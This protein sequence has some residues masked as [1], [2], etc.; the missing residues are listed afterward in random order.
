VAQSALDR[1]ALREA[2]A[3]LDVTLTPSTESALER[4]AYL[5]QAANRDQNLTRITAPAD[6]AVQHVADSLACLAVLDR[7]RPLAVADVGSGAGWPGLA[8]AIACPRWS[9]TLIE[10]SLKKSRFLAAAVRELELGDRVV[11]RAERA[12]DA[13][14]DPTLRETH[15]AALARAVAPLATLC[16]YLLPLVAVGGK[17]VA[18][19]TGDIDSERALASDAGALLGATAEETLAY[20]LPGLSSERCLVIWEKGLAT[21]QGYPR[22]AGIPRKR[23]LTRS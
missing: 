13:G 22:R 4:H 19:K 11:V 6:V 20:R 9:V 7:S 15:D 21:P 17:A 14:H 23:P 1:T 8:L 18:F 2:L 3:A 5:V 16:E 12:E 10:S